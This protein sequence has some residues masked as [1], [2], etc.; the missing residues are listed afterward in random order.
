MAD[1]KSEYIEYK[2]KYI[3]YKLKYMNLQRGGGKK[4][5]VLLDGPSSSGKTMIGKFLEKYGYKLISRD[6]I[7]YESRRRATAEYFKNAPNEYGFDKTFVENMN[8]YFDEMDSKI[9]YEL[10]KIKKK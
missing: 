4:N 9:M 7:M 3:E 5:I 2:L 10:G 1:Y 8:K 6:D